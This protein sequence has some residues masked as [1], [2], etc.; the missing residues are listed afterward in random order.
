VLRARDGEED[1]RRYTNENKNRDQSAFCTF[2]NMSVEVDQ[3]RSIPFVRSQL[4][5]V[6]FSRTD[7][8]LL[9][10]F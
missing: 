9:N 4:E 8:I 5:K 6:I 10:L 2:F 1:A 3:A 7:D